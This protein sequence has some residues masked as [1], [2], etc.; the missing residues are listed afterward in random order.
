MEAWR[1]PMDRWAR[2]CD[3]LGGLE[4][5]IGEQRRRRGRVEQ[6]GVAGAGL[7]GPVRPDV[8]RPGCEQPDQQQGEEAQDEERSGARRHAPTTLPGA[9]GDRKAGSA[10]PEACAGETSERLREDPGSRGRRA[11]P[12]GRGR[13]PSDDVAQFSPA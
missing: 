13:E 2:R 4:R 10:R 9:P 6:A 5:E 1:R 7:V 3:A 8:G 12:F 11:R